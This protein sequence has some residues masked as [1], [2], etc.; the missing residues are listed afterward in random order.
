M[1]RNFDGVAAA[2]TDRIFTGLRDCKGSFFLNSFFFLFH[3]EGDWTLEHFAQG[4]GAVSMLGDTQTP[5]GHSP[6]L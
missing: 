1:H 2:H 4:G 5:K 3:C 6:E